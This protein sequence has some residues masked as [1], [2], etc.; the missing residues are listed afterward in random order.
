HATTST[1]DEALNCG[2]DY[3]LSK[4]FEPHELLEIL[5]RE[6]GLEYEYIRHSEADAPEKPEKAQENRS[7]EWPG[8]IIQAL[9]QTLDDG[10]MADFRKNLKELAGIDPDSASLMQKLAGAY[11]Y[12]ELDRII[13]RAEEQL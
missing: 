10:D 11:D 12:Q 2:A 4:P 13:S 6:L 9:R 7:E 1:K 5:G 8:H 3:F